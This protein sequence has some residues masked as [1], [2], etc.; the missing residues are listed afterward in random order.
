[1]TANYKCF[2]LTQLSKIWCQMAVLV[3]VC[4]SEDPSFNPIAFQY[5]WVN[6]W[7]S[8]RTSFICIL[9]NI[10]WKNE[11]LLWIYLYLSWFFVIFFHL[12]I[13]VKN[14][15]IYHYCRAKGHFSTDYPRKCRCL[16]CKHRFEKYFVVEKETKIKGRLFLCFIKNYGF[17]DWVFKEESN[18]QSSRPSA[19]SIN[20]TTDETSGQISH[21]LQSQVH[22]SVEEDLQ[23]ITNVKVCKESSKWV[24][25]G[26]GRP[27]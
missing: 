1:M 20:F 14:Y 8:L 5:T 3:V 2:G 23:I 9:L 19:S 11:L 26:S 4:R 21:I 24:E 7:F 12:R 17:W 15:E 6:T 13:C 16:N 27:D 25:K 10:G 22:I 18:S